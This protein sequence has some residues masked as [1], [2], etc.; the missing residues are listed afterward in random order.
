MRAHGLMVLF[1]LRL[2]K[3]EWFSHLQTSTVQSWK[4]T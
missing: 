4:G 1:G 2:R 3:V